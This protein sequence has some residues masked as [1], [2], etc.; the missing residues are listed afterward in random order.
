M[1]SPQVECTILSLQSCL[2]MFLHFHLVNRPLQQLVAAWGLCKRSNRDSSE[3]TERPRR[4]EKIA[5]LSF[6][7][8]CVALQ[9]S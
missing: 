7:L 1:K 4:L 5:E 3:R 9:S 2:I 6:A 8:R